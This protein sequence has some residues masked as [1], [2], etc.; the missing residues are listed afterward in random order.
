MTSLPTD[1][2]APGHT[3]ARRAARRGRLSWPVTA[4]AVALLLASAASADIPQLL[5]YQGYLTDDAGQPLN[6]VQAITFSIH[7]A[8]E[9][10]TQLWSETQN[11][12][13]AN[14]LFNILLGTVTLIPAE[15]FDGDQQYLAVRVGAGPELAP[16][17]RLVSVGHCFTAREAERLDG[18]AASAYVRNVDGVAPQNGNVDLVAGANVTLTPNG[19]A[20]SIT[21]ASNA[22][23]LPFSSTVSS[24]QTA[25]TVQNTGSGYAMSASS[26]TS[27]GLVA[28][29]QTSYG[30]RAVSNGTTGYG[31]Y[32]LANGDDARG[33][34]GATTGNNAYGVWGSSQKFHGV[35]GSSS[36]G[37]GV[38]GTQ[39]NS[40]TIG[41]LASGDYGAYGRFGESP[42]LNVGWLGAELAGAGG[43]SG[44]GVG[45]L[46]T[47]V[48]GDGVR[49][50]S[51]GGTGVHGISTD[52]DAAGVLGSN[53]AGDGVHGDSQAGVGVRGSSL[54]DDG[55]VGDSDDAYGVRGV[56]RDA[57]RAGVLGIGAGGGAGV[58]GRNDGG[59]GVEGVSANGS[60]LV[61]R[62][63]LEV[64]GAYKGDIAS[65]SATDGAP[66]PRPA[67]DSGW[68]S[69]PQG[70]NRAIEHGVGGDPDDYV[71]DMEF[72]SG[73]FG[74]NNAG[75]GGDIRSAVA[76]FGTYWYSLGARYVGVH[77]NAD[78]NAAAEVRIRIWVVR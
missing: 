11:V 12:M 26:N 51:D 28:S 19:P 1:A 18:R 59:H 62:G 65:I 25:L 72:R 20:G 44:S 4:L 33:V 43:Q 64:T 41:L 14:G 78:D 17:T 56:T 55:V 31:V 67:F 5:S 39:S 57:A 27:Y 71:V 34:V 61:A 9:K 60:A 10:G 13:V 49:G 36:T 6:G 54:S 74:R 29:S 7:D 50:H 68:V 8:A 15:V 16:R 53:T 58:L 3:D 48:S 37:I 77:R 40:G 52:G 22:L 45:V 76:V 35:H 23:S 30:V 32:G 24:S 46:G 75:Y 70:D 63:D 47:S 66:F 38:Y 42:Q 21:I 2:A 69:V 73:E